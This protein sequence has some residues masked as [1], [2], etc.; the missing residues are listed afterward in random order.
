MLY[1]GQKMSYSC[2]VGK[3]FTF[4]RD[5]KGNLNYKHVTNFV[6][7]VVLDRIEQISEVCEQWMLYCVTYIIVADTIQQKG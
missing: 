3:S 4:Q 1:Y 2:V 6:R 5:K 7:L